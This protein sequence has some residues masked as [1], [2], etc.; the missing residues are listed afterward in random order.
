MTIL[1]WNADDANLPSTFQLAQTLDKRLRVPQS[2][3][4][5]MQCFAQTKIFKD[6]FPPKIIT[7]LVL[8]SPF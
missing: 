4:G 1:K 2:P 8:Q 7:P 5:A 3:S 6:W